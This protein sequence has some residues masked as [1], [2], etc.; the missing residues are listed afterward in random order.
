AAVSRARETRTRPPTPVHPAG[1][2]AGRAAVDEAIGGPQR[3]GAE[4]RQ[5]ASDAE[6]RGEGDADGSPHGHLPLDG[7]V[8][9]IYL[10]LEM[11]EM[12]LVSRLARALADE[13]RLR[14]LLALSRGE[15]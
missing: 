7:R 2:A 10:S 12:Q 13:T 11:S 1:P 5:R 6:R 4:K 9:F 3:R 15:A 14:I 8:H